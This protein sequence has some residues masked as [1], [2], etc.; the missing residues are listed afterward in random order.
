MICD[1]KSL[2]MMLGYIHMSILLFTIPVI[3]YGFFR[4]VHNRI[5]YLKKTMRS[6]ILAFGLAI[7]FCAGTHYFFPQVFPRNFI[8]LL[9]YYAFTYTFLL[10]ELMRAVLIINVPY[11]D[12]TK[13]YCDKI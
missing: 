6:G 13:D 10:L 12:S 4:K 3:L 7:L 8:L 2:S 11:N 5:R 9:A 1:L